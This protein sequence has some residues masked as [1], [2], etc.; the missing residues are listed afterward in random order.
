MGGL[1]GVQPTNGAQSVLKNNGALV[2]W[3][4]V[5][6]LLAAAVAAAPPGQA[7]QLAAA[8]ADDVA[9]TLAKC[10]EMEATSLQLERLPVLAALHCCVAGSVRQDI[11]MLPRVAR[12]LEATLQVL[13]PAAAQTLSLATV[14]GLNEAA[15]QLRLGYLLQVALNVA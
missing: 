14:L 12:E 5:R 1:G 8:L 6:G 10:V 11:L 7:P 9:A 3:T 15:T 2:E 13:R 4:A